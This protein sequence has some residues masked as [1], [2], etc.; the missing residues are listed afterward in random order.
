ML[1]FGQ[2]EIEPMAEETVEQ[3]LDR[4]ER[5]LTAKSSALRGQLAPVE[6]E[7]LK[8]QRMR[9]ALVEVQPKRPTNALTGILNQ[10]GSDFPWAA[11]ATNALARPLNSVPIADLVASTF[12]NR[13][14]KDLI[15]QALLDAFPNGANLSELRHFIQSGYGREVAQGSLR[16]QIHRLKHAGILHQDLNS[17]LW[18]FHTGKRALYSRYDHPSSRKNDVLLQ[19]DP[20]PVGI[21]NQ[22]PDDKG[23]MS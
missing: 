17:D 12:A 10:S 6:A 13:S 8:V 9:S 5:E 20:V 3:F 15:I 22:L 19:D 21:L 1:D 11:T 4:R 14:I 18:N 2:R 23:D 7:L 16:T